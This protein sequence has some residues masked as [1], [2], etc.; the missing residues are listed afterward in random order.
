MILYGSPVRDKIKEILIEK[1]KKLLKKPV[2]VVIQVGDREDSNIYIKQKQKFG[3]EIGVDVRHLKME[4]ID[5][6]NKTEEYLLT[7]IKK[8]NE[9]TEIDGII[10]QLPLPDGFDKDKILNSIDIKKDVDG[11]VSEPNQ[12]VIPATARGVIA[13]LD[14]YGIEIKGK[15]ATVIGQGFL[16]GKPIANE[17]EKRGAQVARCDIDTKNIPEISRNSHILIT[18]VGEPNLIKNN[19]V[20]E[21]QVVIDVGISRI[22]D[23]TK[24]T[25]IVGDVDFDNVNSFVYAI[26]PVPGGVGPV[27]VACLFQNLI[28]KI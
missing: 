12:N 9:D 20:N 6:L 22:V 16:V 25:K 11:L 18:A 21:K 27:T 28:D 5:N 26:T 23:D 14:F 1:I 13:L 24:K 19:F 3:N 8:L 15:K 2:L 7:V 4:N 17:L 10:V